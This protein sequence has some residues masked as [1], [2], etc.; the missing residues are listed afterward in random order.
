MVG[1][2]PA[3][4]RTAVTRTQYPVGIPQ[5]VPLPFRSPGMATVVEKDSRSRRRNLA[6]AQDVGEP[7]GPVVAYGS[8]TA[9]FRVT[10]TMALV[11]GAY[12]LVGN[13]E[14]SVGLAGASEDSGSAPLTTP[15]D[16]I[17][18]TR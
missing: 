1:R 5:D 3:V 9:K 15:W 16:G 17:A 4:A 2:W 14:P 6:R 18:V 12:L 7:Y 11:V 13:V 10:E 8:G